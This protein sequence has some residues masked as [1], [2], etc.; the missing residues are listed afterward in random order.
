M[1]RRL[2]GLFS[3][4]LVFTFSSPGSRVCNDMAQGPRAHAMAHAALDTHEHHGHAPQGSRPPADHRAPLNH[5]PSASPCASVLLVADAAVQSID[6]L[7]NDGIVQVAEL[8][9]SSESTDLEPPPPKA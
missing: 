5:C 1:R 2:A 3:C 7:H 8:E 9:P 6:S 4:M